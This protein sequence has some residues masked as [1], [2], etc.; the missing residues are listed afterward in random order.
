[1]QLYPY[2]LYYTR[3]FTVPYTLKF[4]L[5]MNVSVITLIIRE[6]KYIFVYEK[7]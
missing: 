3:L 1:M 5:S 6:K 4:F 2:F 7:K